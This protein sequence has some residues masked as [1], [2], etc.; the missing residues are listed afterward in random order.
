MSKK[1]A[2][3]PGDGIGID[4]SREAVR[5]LDTL[6]DL[7]KLPLDY[8][9][10][11][12]GA[13][14]YLA[15]GIGLPKENLE[16]FRDNYDAVFLG[17]LGDPRIP[18]MAH[19]REILLGMRFKL[20]L[21]VNYRPVILF[22]ERLCPLKGKSS[23]DIN[24]AAF[25]ENTEGLYVGVGGHF[26]KGTEDEIALQE[27]VNS[28]KGVE[29]IIDHAFQFAQKHGRRKVTMSDK[30]NAMRFEG[31]LWMRVFDEV[32]S[33]Y[34]AIEA[35]HLFVDVLSM[36]LV[37]APERF[38]VIVTCN[39]FG[40]IVTDLGAS[41]AGGLGLAASANINPGRVSLFEPVHGSAPKY[42][43]K[44]TANP[45]AAILTLGLLLEYIGFQEAANDITQ[46][47]GDAVRAVDCT[48]DLGGMLGTAEAGTAICNRLRQLH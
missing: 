17:A 34:P 45:F 4:V 14:K 24:I 37:R 44:N 40:D 46:V 43:G 25:R 19:G 1:I 41:L 36:Q 39:M 29:R 8:Q 28:Y 18:D 21:Y 15:T 20:D 7:H 3:I 38:D 42:A 13:E 48:K 9:E 16:D 5:V 27:S 11:D 47:I 2:V 35:E 22:D 23:K 10:F 6:I 30:N 33:R 32:A 26:K 12:F 31:D